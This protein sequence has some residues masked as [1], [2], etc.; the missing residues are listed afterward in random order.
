MFMM[1]RF[2]REP[3]TKVFNKNSEKKSIIF[4]EKTT[5]KKN[6]LILGYKGVILK[7]QNA[8]AMLPEKK[9]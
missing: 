4:I 8:H 1:R 6:P 9:I 5:H 7:L 2:Q 3:A